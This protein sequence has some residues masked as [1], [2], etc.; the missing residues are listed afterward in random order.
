MLEKSN[1]ST[2]CLLI[3]QAATHTFLLYVKVQLSP[4][5]NMRNGITIYFWRII[6]VYPIPSNIVI[7]EVDAT[8]EC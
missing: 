8:T 2:V 4:L 6:I 3:L 5:L 7:S 1:S